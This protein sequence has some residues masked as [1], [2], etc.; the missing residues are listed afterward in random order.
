MAA[1]N[2]VEL[3]VR[4]ESIQQ[5]YTLY[6]ADRFRVNRR[7]QRKL[8]W[9]VEEKQR[10]IDSI[11]LALPLPLFLVAEISSEPDSPL[12]LIDGMQRM[13]AIFAFIEQEFD[14]NGE[15]F[16]LATLADT[17]ALLDAGE[18]EQQTPILDRSKSV[19]IANYSLALSVFRASD[20]SSIDEVFRRINSG[21]RRLSKQELRQ[22]GTISPLADMVRRLASVIRRDTSP[23]DSV[24]LRKMPML[25]ISNR[26]LKYGV[27]VTDIFWV[28]QNILRRDDVRESLDEQ[29]IL[30]ILVDCLV[31]P[32]STTNSQSRDAFYDFTA[33]PD[34]VE[35]PASIIMSSRIEAVGAEDVERRFLAV[36]DAIRS[37]LD[38]SDQSFV[39]LIGLPPSGRGG[40]YFHA[41]FVALWEA[42][43]VDTPTRTLADAEKA[44]KAFRGLAASASTT[45]G[46]DWAAEPKRQTI[47]AFKGILLPYMTIDTHAK[48]FG[49]LASTSLLE[50]I[51]TN[52]RV[53]QPPFDCKQG[54]FSLNPNTRK[55]D[56][57]NF[58]KIVKTFTAMA[59]IGPGHTSYLLLGAADDETDAGVVKELDK[60]SSY[61]LA[62]FHIVGIGREAVLDGKNLNDY[63]SWII[64]RIGTHPSLPSGFAKQ[65]TREA[66]LVSYKDAA[67]GLFKVTAQSAPVFYGT[68][69]YDRE[70]SSTVAVAPGHA[71]FELY[72]RFSG[73][74]QGQTA[75][76]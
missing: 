58:D 17:K 26:S 4:S 33:D 34:Q 29:T 64:Q 9:S 74:A 63:W 66:R 51:L 15:Y 71:Q 19:T 54:L 53:E 20:P 6:R 32:M 27:N 38:N 59:N 11:V 52:A 30:D 43:F 5:A 13:N 24:P 39:K 42:M 7:Y 36:Y 41:V 68:E 61:E 18:L 76:V 28:A 62:G 48:D 31:E 21:G 40:R 25:S 49:Q 14:Y 56:Q 60:I 47:N 65:L 45:S 57:G 72:S 16:D 22:A 69:L 8:V 75:N 46:G 67:L 23:G 70:G 35:T 3:T 50:T 2:P 37:V 1:V 44:V 73:V 12:E 10:L 55:F